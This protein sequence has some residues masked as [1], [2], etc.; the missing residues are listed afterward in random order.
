[1]IA[2]TAAS[3]EEAPILANILELY[4]HDFS[5]FFDIELGDDGRFGYD[6]LALYWTEEGRHPFLIR[7]DGKLAG[8]ALVK[9]DGELWDMAEFF[10]TRGWRRKGIGRQAAHEVFQKFPGTWQVRV[11]EAN[12][13]GERFWSGAIEV[14]AA[15]VEKDGR[16]WRVFTFQS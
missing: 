6:S 7:V 12:V 8:F 9:R 1:V 5:D 2:V 3:A 10:V 13:A 15:R 14:P 4:A 16:W 11:M